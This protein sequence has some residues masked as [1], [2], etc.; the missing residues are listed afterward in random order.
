LNVTL[1]NEAWAFW[2]TNLADGVYSV[3]GFLIRAG[4]AEQARALGYQWEAFL[5]WRADAHLS[6]NATI[7]HFWAGAFFDTST[8]GRDITYTA[9]WAGYKF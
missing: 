9:A 3:P 1:T 2:R 4:S 7:A 6:L 5:A 8:P